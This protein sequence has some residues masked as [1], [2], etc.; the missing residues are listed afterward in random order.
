[1]QQVALSWLAYHLTGSAVLLGAIAFLTL[2]PQ[3]LVGPLAG[4]GRTATT[5]AAC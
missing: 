5:S 1:M 4:P 3:L 2:L